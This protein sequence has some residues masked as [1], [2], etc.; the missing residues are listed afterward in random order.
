ME[1]QSGVAGLGS[2]HV[3]EIGDAVKTSDSGGDES[4]KAP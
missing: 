3:F 2:F 1:R 4:G